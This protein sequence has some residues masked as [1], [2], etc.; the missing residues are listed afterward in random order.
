VFL[1]IK[2]LVQQLPPIDVSSV[3]AFDFVVRYHFIFL[4]TGADDPY[5]PNPKAG[6]NFNG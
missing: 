6:P 4:P 5:Q 2:Q 1:V 3:H